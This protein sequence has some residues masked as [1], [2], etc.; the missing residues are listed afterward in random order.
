MLGRELGVTWYGLL[1]HDQV[2]APSEPPGGL[3]RAVNFKLVSFDLPIL[4]YRPYRAFAANQ[5]STLLFQ[6]FTGA[7]VPYDASIDR[8]PG[9]PL[10]ALRTVWS[11]GLRLVYDWRY[12][13]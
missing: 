8:P 2:F 11:L 4:E 13:R 12:Y 5:S 7:D 1:S 9:A 6:L 3:G 10:P